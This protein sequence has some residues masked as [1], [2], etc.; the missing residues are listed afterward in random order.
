M[1][2]LGLWMCVL[3]IAIAA[4]DPADA[5]NRRDKGPPPWAPAH[6]YR[7][8]HEKRPHVP[9]YHHTYHHKHHHFRHR[10]DRHEIRW[11]VPVQRWR[12]HQHESAVIAGLVGGAIGSLLTS[13]AP[14]A[15]SPQFPGPWAAPRHP[16]PSPSFSFRGDGQPPS[17]SS[18]EG[19][20]PPPFFS[21]D[22]GQ[23][24]SPGRYCREFS[25][26]ALIGGRPQEIYGVACW[27]PDGSWE[28]VSV[29]RR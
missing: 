18:L 12:F 10:H 24:P 2:R 5:G 14:A 9:S 20:Q 17:V 13:S 6:G 21:L 8:K 27:Q 15:L 4:P 26:D 19:S 29:D 1:K 28:V 3:A 22:G 7:H 11:R 25:R 23:P 16:A